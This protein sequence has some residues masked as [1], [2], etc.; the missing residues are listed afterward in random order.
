MAR[1]QDAEPELLTVFAGEDATD[2]ETAEIESTAAELFPD[3]EM[4]VLSGGQ[5]HYHFLISLE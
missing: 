3:A 2:E 4:E 1:L 5:P